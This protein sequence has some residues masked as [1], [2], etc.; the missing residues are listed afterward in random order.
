MLSAANF[1]S[2]IG[3]LILLDYFGRK[4]LMLFAQFGCMISMFGM[5]I[6]TSFIENDIALYVFAIGFFVSFANGPGCILWLYMA[7]ICN[8][9][10]TSVNTVVNWM[11]QIFMS[12]MTLYFNE[13]LK[14][15]IWLLFGSLCTIGFF[16]ILIFMKETRGVP[17]DQL[18]QLY[19]KGS[20]DLNS[21]YSSVDR[22]ESK[23]S[24]ES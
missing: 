10:A 13:W 23:M 3:P 14:G 21:Q 12:I 24:I 5:W 17:Q 4:T 19:S 16:Y 7:E 6:F 18:R 20:G 11:W 15:Y 2:S 9:K 1:F 22:K 8:D